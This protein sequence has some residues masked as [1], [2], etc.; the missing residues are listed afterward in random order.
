MNQSR[1]WL[2]FILIFSFAAPCLYAENNT[3]WT[4]FIYIESSHKLHHYALCNIN[5]IM[6]AK[7]DENVHILVQLHT[8]QD[9]AWRYEITSGQLHLLDT[10]SITGSTATNVINGMQWAVS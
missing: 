3:S 5:E 8:G 10:I 6:Q 9:I 1:L 2:F 4:F 7:I